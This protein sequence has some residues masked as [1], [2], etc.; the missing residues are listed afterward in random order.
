VHRRPSPALVVALLALFVALGG[1]AQAARLITAKDVK[2]NSLTGKQIKNGSLSVADLSKGGQTNL[3]RTPDRSITTAKLGLGAVTADRLAPNAVSGPQVAD[4]SLGGADI[5]A[6]A[7]GSDE[8]APNAVGG[9]DIASGA[10]DSGEIADGGLGARD[11]GRFTGMTGAL[12]FGT[13]NLGD[14]KSVATASL[15]P[16]VAGQSLL[17][18]VVVVTP[19]AS[20][21]SAGLAVS[22][23]PVSAS[24]IEVTICNVDGPAILNLGDTPLRYVSFDVA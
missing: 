3:R 6:N 17:D 8:I 4:D 19:Q 23:K 7:I 5:A 12:P 18:D 20:F 15:T 16:I 13:I 14:C 24:Q 10:I 11:I 21:P 22:A 9:A 2:R 1:P